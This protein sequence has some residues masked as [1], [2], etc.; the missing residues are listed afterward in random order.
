MTEYSGRSIEMGFG[1]NVKTYPRTY[2][3]TLLVMA[4]HPYTLDAAPAMEMNMWKIPLLE[5]RISIGLSRNL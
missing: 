5:Q 3:R 4:G 2:Y 1:D